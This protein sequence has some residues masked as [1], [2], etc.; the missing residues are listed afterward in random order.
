MSRS[1]YSDDCENLN[2]Y[3]ANVDRA[4]GGKRGQAFLR[5]LRAALDA[6]PEPKRLI[7]DELKAATGEVCA[8][9]SVGLMRGLDMQKVDYEEPRAVGA[10]FG[11]TSILAAE[12]AFVNDEGPFY[13]RHGTETPEARY[14]RVSRWVNENLLAAPVAEEK[15]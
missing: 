10:L 5:D 7:A 3:R 13:W 15:R 1:G 9:G 14:E 11:I 6:L 2:L 12:I 4:I 8:M